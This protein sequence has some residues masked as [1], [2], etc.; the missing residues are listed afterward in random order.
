VRARAVPNG[1]LLFDDQGRV[2]HLDTERSTTAGF[3]IR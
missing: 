3:A 2:L 1:W